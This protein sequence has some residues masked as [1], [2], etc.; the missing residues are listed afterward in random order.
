MGIREKYPR[1]DER[2]NVLFIILTAIVL[3][4]FLTQMVSQSTDQQSDVIVRQTRDDEISRMM[5]Q[6]GALGGAVHQMLVNGAD[7]ATLYSN[8]ST[9]K[10][11][12]AGYNTA[13]HTYKIY[14]PLGGGIAHMDASSPTATPM[15]TDFKINPETIIT[16]I[17]PTDVTIGDIVF[18]AK[19]STAAFCARINEL[20]LNSATIPVMTTSTFDDMFDGTTVTIDGSNCADCVEKPR[21][22][23]SNSAG[24]EWGYYAALL[25]G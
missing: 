18:T 17:G 16:G 15:A 19:V 4:A 14:H 12:D 2:G 1:P 23:V 7:P 5:A 24:T 22:C 21:L 10:A 6:V 3:L 11:G 8:I 13:P 25:P 20:S 9:L